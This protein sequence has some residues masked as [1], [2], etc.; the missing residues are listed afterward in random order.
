MISS[1]NFALKC[2]LGLLKGRI[3]LYSTKDTK[4]VCLDNFTERNKE[5]RLQL[6]K[7]IPEELSSLS[8]NL[9]YQA[10]LGTRT[11]LPEEL[12][13][14]FNSPRDRLPKLK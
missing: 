5:F 14:F 10:I 13:R 6:E 11:T 1:L 4:A 9:T 3:C 7:E 2:F 12:F 8:S